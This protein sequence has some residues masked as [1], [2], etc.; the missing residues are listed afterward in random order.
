MVKDFLIVWLTENQVI[1][2][3]KIKKGFGYKQNALTLCLKSRKNAL[4]LCKF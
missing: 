1:S 3:Q 2:N 4:T